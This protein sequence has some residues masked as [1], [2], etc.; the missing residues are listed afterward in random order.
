MT[1][2]LFVGC[3]TPKSRPPTT[4]TQPPEFLKLPLLYLLSS[5]HPRIYVEV[6]AVE[7]CEPTEKALVQLQAFLTNHCQKPDGVEI[8]VSDIIPR[9]VARHTTPRT[10]GRRYMNGPPDDQGSPPAFMYVLYYPG[11]PGRVPPFAD[12]APYPAIYFNTR[13]SLGIAL[14]EILLHEAGHLLGLVNRTEHAKN[15]HCWNSGCAMNN[16]WGYLRNFGWLPWRKHSQFCAECV[17]ELAQATKQSPLSN[18]RY[19]GPVLVRAESDY[20]VLT[21]PERFLLVVGR[22]NESDCQQFIT[23]VRAAPD[24]PNNWYRIDCRAKEETFNDPQQVCRIM[25]GIRTDSFGIIRQYGPGVLLQAALRRYETTQQYTNAIIL[26]Q[27]AIQ[28]ASDEAQ[29][30][31]LLAWIKATCPDDAVRNGAEAVQIAQQACELTKWQEGQPIDT[32][33][34]AYA[35]TGDFR[36]AIELQRQA[37]RTGKPNQTEQT[38]MRERLA[39]YQQ[40]KPYHEQ[41]PQN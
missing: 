6:D 28:S 30:Y 20:D 23:S 3:T 33:A 35:E 5:P 17:N 16:H 19:V 36:R 29:N 4:V 2:L 10:L 38:A 25:D 9:K 26:L 24:N 14:D 12:I 1:G 40:S 11:W 21:L 41:P 32:L 22:A 27:H 31:N 34:A 7:G 18:L 13:F 8:M 37:L 15:G 39:L